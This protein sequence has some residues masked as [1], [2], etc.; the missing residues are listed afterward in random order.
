[1]SRWYER[2]L[3]HEAKCKALEQQATQLIRAAKPKKV[4]SPKLAPLPL[5]ETSGWLPL[6]DL[7]RALRARRQLRKKWA[8]LI[9]STAN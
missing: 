9:R 1:V 5:T 2:R 7:K 8:C 3:E 4:K 6:A